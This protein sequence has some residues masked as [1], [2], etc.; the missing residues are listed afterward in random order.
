MFSYFTGKSTRKDCNVLLTSAIPDKKFVR[1]TYTLPVF[2]SQLV[3]K[4]LK[5]IEALSYLDLA[6]IARELGK[7]IQQNCTSIDSVNIRYVVGKLVSKYPNVLGELEESRVDYEVSFYC[8]LFTFRLE[9]IALF[10]FIESS[11]PEN[12]YLF[13]TET[14]GIGYQKKHEGRSS[15]KGQQ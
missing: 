14:S 1:A 8:S 12:I 11:L 15:N 4:K 10:L 5:K 13:R 6:C 3:D 2:F 7:S 9:L